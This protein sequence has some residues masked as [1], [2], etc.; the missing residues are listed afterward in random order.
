MYYRLKEG[1]RKENKKV[2]TKA[3]GERGK[4]K[5]LLQFRASHQH[6]L[7]LSQT[8][9]PLASKE[10]FTRVYAIICCCCCFFLLFVFE[11][12]KLRTDFCNEALL[13]Y[14]GDSKLFEK[15]EKLSNKKKKK[16]KKTTKLKKAFSEKRN[17]NNNNKENKSKLEKK[18][19]HESVVTVILNTINNN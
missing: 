10:L 15:Q 8:S 2:Y 16:K 5:R 1:K 11:R 12:G 13:R 3:R 9:F 14:L 17:N 6:G 4:K 7:S 18:K 19:T